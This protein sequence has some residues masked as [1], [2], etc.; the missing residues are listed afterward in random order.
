VVDYLDEVYGF[1]LISMAQPGSH[2][3]DIVG[4]IDS[5]P[6]QIE[7]KGLANFGSQI[8]MF[9]KSVR[10]GVECSILDR[11]AQ[12]TLGAPNFES[13]IDSFIDDSRVHGFAEDPCSP[14][15][16]SVPP[17]LNQEL[18]KHLGAGRDIV[19]QHLRDSG[20]THLGIY[21][22]NSDDVIIYSVYENDPLHLPMLP[23]LKEFTLATHGGPY[24]GATRFG[25]RIK[26]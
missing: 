11:L 3:P 21:S 10:R 2:G 5:F 14:K 18:Q 13:M 12:S 26:I 7:V 24:K 8:S 9:D 16:G 17:K 4:L 22:R 1:N 6:I 19:L 25:V 23:D 20:D 15:S